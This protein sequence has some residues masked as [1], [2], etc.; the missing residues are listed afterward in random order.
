MG[1]DR[2][3]IG[4]PFALLGNALHA[5]AIERLNRIATDAAAGARHHDPLVACHAE[6]TRKIV[7][8]FG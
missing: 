4:A 6:S 2:S 3:A 5:K 7:V 8:G 1:A